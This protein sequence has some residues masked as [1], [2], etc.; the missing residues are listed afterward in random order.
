M[1]A[2]SLP[3]WRPLLRQMTRLGRPVLFELWGKLG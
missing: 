3:V 1:T 2:V